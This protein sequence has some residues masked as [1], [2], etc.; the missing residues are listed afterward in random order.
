MQ[1]LR[2]ISNLTLLSFIFVS[3]CQEINFPKNNK[4][5]GSLVI[6]K[7]SFLEWFSLGKSYDSSKTFLQRHGR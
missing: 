1:I 3:S 5:R 2:N 4:M 7:I 6:E